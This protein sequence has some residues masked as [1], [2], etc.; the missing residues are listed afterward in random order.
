MLRRK[1]SKRLSRSKSTASIQS[2]SDTMDPDM[3]RRH[4]YAAAT[5]AFARAQERSSADMGYSHGNPRSRQNTSS[6]SEQTSF[7]QSTTTCSNKGEPTLHR[8]TSVRFAGPNAVPRKRS[9]TRRTSSSLQSKASSSALRPVAI[10]TDASVPG[11]YRPPDRSS[12]IG[13]ANTGSFVTTLSAYD[14]YYR[15]EDEIPST[16]SSYRRIRKSKSTFGLFKPPSIFYSTG[17]PNGYSSAYN[18]RRSSLSGSR[19]PQSQQYQAPLRAPKS[20]SFL[21]GGRTS[22]LR[23]S[24]DEAVQMAR[25]RFFQEATQ[26]R[27][28]EQPSFLF[29]SRAQR[30]EK[31]FRKSLRSSSMNSS[32]LPVASANQQVTSKEPSLRDK[33]RQASKSIRSKIKRVFGFSK[34]K[35]VTVPNQQVDARDTHV[36]DYFP[37]PNSVQGA[38]SDIPY[39]DDAQRSRA[40]S[41]TSLRGPTSSEN[42][43]SRPSSLRSGRSARSLRSEHSGDASR[44]TSWTSTAANTITSQGARILSA[45]EQQRLSIIREHGTHI[46]SSNFKRLPSTNQIS[47]NP[48]TRHTGRSSRDAPPPVL[49]LVN[50]ARVYSA[51]MKRLDENSPNQILPESCRGSLENISTP[52]N[53]QGPSSSVDSGRGNQTG[54]TIRQVQEEGTTS[55]TTNVE[56]SIRRGHQWPHPSSIPA[57]QTGA[58]PGY[59]GARPHQWRTSDL[60]HGAHVR[61]DDDVFAQGFAPDA[62]HRGQS[63]SNTSTLIISRQSNTKP[64]CYA[65]PGGSVHTPQEIALRNEPVIQERRLR[66]ESRSAFFGGSQVTISRNTSPFRRAMA[67]SEHNPAAVYGGAPGYSPGG[68]SLFQEPEQITDEAENIDN[69]N[70]PCAYSAS[71]YS[72]TTGGQTLGPANSNISLLVD[73]QHTP[74]PLPHNM[75]TGDV[76]IIDRATYRPSMPNSYGN[77]VTV[78]AGSH[79]WKRWMSSEVAKLERSKE[80][81][82]SNSYVNYALPTMPK[83]LHTKHTLESA[84]TDGAD[85]RIVVQQ[86]IVV[87]QPLGVISHQNPNIS[88][89]SFPRPI[90]KNRS[91]VS[92]VE[93]AE[94]TSGSISST[95][96]PV[97]PPPPPPIPIRSPLRSPKSKTPC[98]SANGYNPTSSISSMDGTRSLHNR[99]GPRGTLRSVRSFET[100]VNVLKNYSRRFPPVPSLGES[101]NSAVEKQFSSLSTRSRTPARSTS[102]EN[103]K[104][105]M[106]L[107]GGT[108]D[109]YGTDGAGLMGPDVGEQSERAAQVM[110]SKRMV[111]LFLSSRRKR[112]TGGSGDSG[113]FL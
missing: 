60:A 84:Q 63:S 103:G 98:R 36:Q 23:Q 61:N 39:P 45:K 38:Y 70:S 105:N 80:N 11:A 20:M 66:R 40:A 52:R 87:E 3:A 91:Q 53:V 31:P 32:A 16:P 68:N 95:P 74:D 69:E 93:N 97:P 29:R 2:K 102:R 85:D 15:H 81:K 47:V 71:L 42:L 55:H 57:A 5:L 90:L 12:S 34:D 7:S 77:H 89:L 59:T 107:T 18:R 26:E 73:E 10:T 48:M 33:A 51:L 106:T 17:S 65:I 64:S 24:N 56:G 9:V 28:R 94:P 111:E 41:R 92:L 35:P 46:P 1:R 43:R 104:S 113:V 49:R 83:S 99:H 82:P 88:N 27:L 86:A 13:K 72:R 79:E 110:G 44:V 109:I 78:S 25:D 19:T 96:I 14:E 101:L 37:G 22:T 54:T 108:D 4:A 100:P 76:V 8:Q 75:S 112:I 30:Q 67:E 6:Q 21:R 58:V 50:S 62:Q